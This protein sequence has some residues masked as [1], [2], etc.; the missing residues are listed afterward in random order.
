MRQTNIPKRITGK[1]A[2]TAQMFLAGF[3]FLVLQACEIREIDPQT[4]RAILDDEAAGFSA[5]EFVDENW[6]GQVIPTV[7]LNAI[8]IHYLLA[9]LETDPETATQ[10]G[11]RE[12]SRPYSYLVNGVAE[13]A[14][15]DT[16]SRV[17]MIKLCGFEDSDQSVNILIGPVISGTALRDALP[18]ITFGQFINQ[19]EFA[20]ASREMHNRIQRTVLAEFDIEQAEGRQIQFYGA[21]THTGDEIN[22]TPVILDWA[23]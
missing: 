17:G 5:E 21:F 6:D 9:L 19:L 22:I 23:D 16:S 7:E 20:D 14:E 13:V 8:D 4:G 18:F 3:L 10:Y 11:H 15:V 1:L 12:G 2:V